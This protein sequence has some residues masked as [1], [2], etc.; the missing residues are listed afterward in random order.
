[1]YEEAEAELDK[2]LTPA[3]DGRDRPVSHSGR[4]T[5]GEKAP[6]THRIGVWARLKAGRDAVPA[7]ERNPIPRLSNS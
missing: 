3:K 2:F 1:M 4:F 7:W 5:P 6:G